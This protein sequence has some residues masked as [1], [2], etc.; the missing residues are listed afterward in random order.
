MILNAGFE[1]L[2]L[3][4]LFFLLPTILKSLSKQAQKKQPPPPT[5]RP[6]PAP[7]RARPVREAAPAYGRGL[8]AAPGGPDRA[9][10]P[11][12]GALGEL[13][14]AL[15]EMGRAMKEAGFEEEEPLPPM[16]TPDSLE[17]GPGLEQPVVMGV[18]LEEG[19]SLEMD[20]S[21][22]TPRSAEILPRA[23][24][25][26]RKTPLTHASKL[27]RHAGWRVPRGARGWQRAVIL[28]EILGPPRSQH[29]WEPIGE[30]DR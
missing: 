9:P 27:G 6:R 15:E 29:P 13:E 21:Q 18:S 20:G 14:R 28:S 2:L 30:S 22:E 3:L 19:P 10:A 23:D 8:E 16:A 11:R 7:E 24:Y 1:T 12:R 25:V 5:R 4:L 17:A 26:S